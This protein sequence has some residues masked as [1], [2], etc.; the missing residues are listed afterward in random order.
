MLGNIQRNKVETIDDMAFM[1]AQKTSDILC[2][3][4]A[5]SCAFTHASMNPK[6]EVAGLL[7][8]PPPCGTYQVVNRY[9]PCQHS[10]A[11]GTSVEIGTEDLTNVKAKLRSNEIIIGWGHSHPG[12][13]VFLS[14]DDVAVQIDF[15]AFYPDAVAL[16]IDPLRSNS[17]EYG[18]F[19]VIGERPCALPYKFLVGRLNP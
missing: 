9:V 10:V 1:R 11:T 8:G 12:F 5:L 16:V 6:E 17:I 3:P 18:F 4:H 15:Q 19:R 7:V 13:G 2:R 14:S